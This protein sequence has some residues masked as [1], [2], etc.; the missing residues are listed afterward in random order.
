MPALVVPALIAGGAAGV[1]GALVGGLTVGAILGPA[2]VAFTS[3]LIIGGINTA[4]YKRPKTNFTPLISGGGQNITVR[5]A[6]SPRQVVIGETRVGGSIFYAEETGN[7]KLLHLL[8]AYAGHECESFGLHYFGQETIDADDPTLS[9]TRLIGARYTN[10]KINIL[11]TT[12]GNTGG[13]I[14]RGTTGAGV[15]TSGL[16]Y[17]NAFG[18]DQLT[19]EIT[20]SSGSDGIYRRVITSESDIEQHTMRV[21]RIDNGV[22]QGEQNVTVTL[23]VRHIWVEEKLG[24]ANQ[25]AVSL[26]DISST[27]KPGYKVLGI[28]YAWYELGWNNRLYPQGLENL[29]VVL[30]GT[31]AVY[32]PRTSPPANAWSENPALLLVHYLT[33][34]DYGLSF[35]YSSE[36]NET[37]LITA[38]NVCDESVSL[39]G[40][41]TEKRYTAN[42]SFLTS[43]AP[44]EIIKGLLA[45]MAGRMVWIGGQWHI[46]AGAYITPTITITE[47]DLRGEVRIE[48]RIKRRALFNAIKGTFI[49]PGENYEPVDFRFQESSTFETQDGGQQLFRDVEY[50]FTQSATMAQRLA[51]IELLTARQQIRA[52]LPCKLTVMELVP[53]DTVYVSL[54]RYGW[55]SSPPKV[56][57]VQ[58]LTHT[59]GDDEGIDLY[60]KET[61]SSIYDWNTS[62]EQTVDPA[63][64]TNLPT[65]WDLNPPTS[66]KVMDEIRAQ[67]DGSIITTMVVTWDPGGDQVG[68]DY[69]VQWRIKPDQS[70]NL[71]GISTNFS[72]LKTSFPRA[73]IVPVIDG[74]IYEVR[75]ATVGIAAVSEYSEVI[76]Y[77]IQGKITPPADLEDLDIIEL[78]NGIRRAVFRYLNPPVDFKGYELRYGVGFTGAW[79]TLIPIHT[80]PLPT[81]PYEFISP[82]A[83]GD[84][85]FAAKAIDTTGNYSLNAVIV[86]V[87]LG[88]LSSDFQYEFDFAAQGWPGTKTDCHVNDVT[89]N[90]DPDQTNSWGTS[91]LTW[92]NA[93]TWASTPVSSY[94]YEHTEIDVGSDLTLNPTVFFN[95]DA[96]T[97]LVEEKHKLSG[98][99]YTAYAPLSGDI[100]FRY[101][102]I[103]ITVTL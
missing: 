92:A 45:A 54:A 79:E 40:G 99:S 70:I 59:F 78:P 55:D 35:D 38:A 22:M 77:E 34:T 87:T 29:S 31:K 91:G 44:N 14:G 95:T 68:R 15:E 85:R 16:N 51:R 90:L 63:P 67:A 102:T 26:P 47:D 89:G 11:P 74:Q 49:D 76:E 48:P 81:S 53:G 25:T 3:T 93:G 80:Q 66:I 23:Q 42:G 4:L 2:A 41:G 39:A 30:K 18:H 24:A 103:R 21:E 58:E 60:I 84:Y 8:V 100:T 56:F 7:N 36:I 98:G 17:I 6:A 88:A 82:V 83:A 13:W 43:I 37:K 1:G 33:N 10:L 46:Y 5:E 19:F 71:F 94:T 96:T 61:D 65:P 20:G 57:E 52:F 64:D 62:L 73:E 101:I 12:A 72:S 9:D 28:A 97:T 75:V 86:D 69:I 32:D 27:W 50:P